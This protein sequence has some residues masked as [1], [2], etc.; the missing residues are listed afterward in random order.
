MKKQLFFISRN[1]WFY[2]TFFRL[3]SAYRY[4][5]T[6]IVLLVLFLL[7][8][9]TAYRILSKMQ[10]RYKT[11]YQNSLEQV[12]KA[13]EMQSDMRT[14]QKNIDSQKNSVQ[15]LV[16]SSL[17]HTLNLQELFVL[18]QKNNIKLHSFTPHPEQVLQWYTK[19]MI[20]LECAGSYEDMLLFL[21]HIMASKLFLVCSY[22]HMK[23]QQDTIFSSLHIVYYNFS[24]VFV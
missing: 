8:Y 16:S 13:Q 12:A 20:H 11:L 3:S 2:T 5:L 24:K 14:F 4:I 22:I 18:M 9:F 15:E 23:K 1:T 10:H 19:K 7:W 21:E 17:H 6:G